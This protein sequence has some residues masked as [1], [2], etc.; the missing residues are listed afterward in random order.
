MNQDQ[1]IEASDY[2]AV[3][4]AALNFVFGYVPTDLTG[5][6][7]VEATDYSIVE[8]NAMLFLFTLYCL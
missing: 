6:L 1:L 4:N 7:L 3:E 5:D 8:N 2:T